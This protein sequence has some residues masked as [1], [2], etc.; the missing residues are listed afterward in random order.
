MNGC[1]MG[2][3]VLKVL[4]R[5]ICPLLCVESVELLVKFILV[6]VM[7][8]TVVAIHRFVEEPLMLYPRRPYLEQFGLLKKRY[9]HSKNEE[10]IT[11]DDALLD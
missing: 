8:R 6:T 4:Q 2:F 3:G 11:N 5:E 9:L 7:K 10:T 1:T